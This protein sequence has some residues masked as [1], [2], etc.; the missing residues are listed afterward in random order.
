MI[1][2]DTAEPDT[3]KEYL[4]NK[5]DIE[6]RNLP[7]GDYLVGDVLIERKTIGDFFNSMN[8]S[9]MARQ[10]MSMEA[11]AGVKIL[12]IVGRLPNTYTRQSKIDYD[13]IMSAK[14]SILR[15]FKVLGEFYENDTDL[16]Q[17]IIQLDKKYGRTRKTKLINGLYRYQLSG[18]DVKTRMLCCIP[19]IG[20]VTA[21]KLLAV[22]TI[23]QLAKKTEQEILKKVKVR[24]AQIRK[25]KEVLEK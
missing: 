8:T 19:T 22:Y 24:K 3:I 16:M 6:V 11:S 1:T 20:P 10:L 18:E 7:V 15:D 2:V 4:K 23:K 21:K 25:I 14:A 13:K 9:R 5:A 17:F 12:A